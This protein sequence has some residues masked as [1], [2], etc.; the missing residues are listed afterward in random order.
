M[1]IEIPEWRVPDVESTKPSPLSD[2]AMQLFLQEHVKER[3]VAGMQQA[4]IY[5]S[6]DGTCPEGHT[7]INSTTY[8]DGIAHKSVKCDDGATRELSSPG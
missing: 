4:L 2:Y 5:T 3:P 8:K 7:K 1:A 6:P